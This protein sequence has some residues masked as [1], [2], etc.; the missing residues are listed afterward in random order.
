MRHRLAAAPD[1]S[2]KGHFGAVAQVQ[3]RHLVQKNPI[4]TEVLVAG[5]PARW[6]CPGVD[7]L[8][9][10]SRLST[11]PQVRRYPTTLPLHGLCLLGHPMC[12]QIQSAVNYGGPVC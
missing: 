7:H 1:P 6:Q 2:R 11:K 10:Q 12:K 9:R 5:Q 4:V 8:R 3:R